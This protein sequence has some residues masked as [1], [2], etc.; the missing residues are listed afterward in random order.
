MGVKRPSSVVSRRSSRQAK[1]PKNGEDRSP[2]SA[3]ISQGRTCFQSY[4]RPG[5]RNGPFPSMPWT[6]LN[7]STS[8]MLKSQNPQVA[9]FTSVSDLVS[10]PATCGS[11]HHNQMRCHP[12]RNAFRL[13]F[14][15]VRERERSRRATTA[16]PPRERCF[17]RPGARRLVLELGGEE[18]QVRV[19]INIGLGDRPPAGARLA[20]FDEAAVPQ[21]TL[22]GVPQAVGG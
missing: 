1:R 7:G 21:I 14:P 16:L 8:R 5:I 11:N 17:F 15:Y 4:T 22:S 18:H 9:N 2:P 12:D 13:T 20:L 6:L 3:G 19:V 10:R